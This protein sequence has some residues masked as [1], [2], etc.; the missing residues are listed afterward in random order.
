MTFTFTVETS[1]YENKQFAFPE[2]QKHH[3][4]VNMH[5]PFPKLLVMHR[6]KALNVY[7]LIGDIKQLSINNNDHNNNN[8][9]HAEHWNIMY[10][11]IWFCKLNI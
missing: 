4:Q 5:K 9:V 8:N 6:I 10:T 11:P 2:K 1:A 3:L 7:Q